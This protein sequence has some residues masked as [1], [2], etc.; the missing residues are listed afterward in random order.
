[1]MDPSIW[2]VD[3]VECRYL[4]QLIQGSSENANTVD[5][6]TCFDGKI[7]VLQIFLF[8]VLLLNRPFY[9]QNDDRGTKRSGC[10][11]GLCCNERETLSV[12]F[13]CKYCKYLLCNF[14]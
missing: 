13:G 9:L 8:D 6:L 3:N 4:S 7:K 2:I 10:R 14:S 12:S 11:C 1:M 5:V